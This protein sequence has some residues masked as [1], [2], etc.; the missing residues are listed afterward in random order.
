MSESREQLVG[1]ISKVVEP[2]KMQVDE[3]P[4]SSAPAEGGVKESDADSEELAKERE[5]ER[6]RER[7]EAAWQRKMLTVPEAETLVLLLGSIFL[8]DHQHV[9]QAL[10]ASWSLIQR[11]QSF[12]R[13]SVHVSS[14]HIHSPPPPSK[15]LPSTFLS[16][17]LSM[18]YLSTRPHLLHP[19]TLCQMHLR[20][21]DPLLSKA[22]FYWSRCVELQGKS[23]QI[24]TELLAGYRT[25]VLKHDQIGQVSNMLCFSSFLFLSPDLSPPSL[26]STPACPN[27]T[28]PLSP[29]A[30]AC[31]Q[32]SLEHPVH[33]F[34]L[35]M[36][37]IIDADL[38]SA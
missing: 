20:T 38:S 36:A 21:L 24:R 22:Y 4:A 18:T 27:G 26:C 28:T 10:T 35:A 13:R 12:N 15:Q 33:P 19:L 8:L 5:K 34:V 23:A 25:A 17:V 1:F 14:S 3:A 29:S 6:D 7:E 16:L 32:S 30:G 37:S 11:V 31:P 9:E 2:E